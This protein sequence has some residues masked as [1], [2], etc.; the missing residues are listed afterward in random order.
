MTNKKNK[1]VTL[2]IMAAGMGSRFGGLKQIEP[3]N[4]NQEF[5]LDYSVYDAKK[6]GF[7]KVVFVI[8][9]DIEKIFKET[10]GKRIEKYIDVDYI[11]Q[12][13]NN[14]PSSFKFPEGRTKPWGT[15]HAIM[16][17]QEVIFNPFVIINAD[18]FYGYDAFKKA[19]DYMT[20]GTNFCV[21]GYPVESTLSSN[22]AVKRGICYSK[23]SYLV[24]LIESNCE[25]LDNTIYASPLN[26]EERF[27]VDNNCLCSMN[28]LGFNLSIFK[29]LNEN[30]PL[31]LEKHK[32][33]ILTCEYLIPDLVR[34]SINEEFAK[35]K[36]IPTD[37][38]WLGITYKED[39]ENVKKL[40]IEY[41]EKGLYPKNL[42]D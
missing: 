30:F 26:K 32:N 12:D 16:A 25:V 40:L 21:I 8:K 33:D 11:F 17:A 15:A 10:V 24:D 42:W 3:V 13:I 4:D 9:K 37:A 28:M 22:G 34:K 38:K 31:F 2:L 6:A 35:V 7:N 5:L 27:K 36:L 29:Y 1:D 41:T 18:D 39:L 19:Y 14:I 20:K 23:D